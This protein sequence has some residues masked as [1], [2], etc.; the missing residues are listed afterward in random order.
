MGH[1]L[2]RRGH[3][4]SQHHPA[5]VVLVQTGVKPVYT[6]HANSVD[7]KPLQHVLSVCKLPVGFRVIAAEVNPLPGEAGI[8]IVHFEKQ[9]VDS[10]SQIGNIQRLA[11]IN[12]DSFA[13]FQPEANPHRE[14]L[15]RLSSRSIT[16]R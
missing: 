1:I 16:L 10:G 6:H 7:T 9:L 11:K 4:S 13:P 8:L 5:L 14:N 2:E 15:T 3:E 12:A